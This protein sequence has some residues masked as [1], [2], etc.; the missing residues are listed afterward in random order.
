M[1]WIG[2][3]QVPRNYGNV[4]HLT[5]SES[6]IRGRVI[7]HLRWIVIVANKVESQA[8]S[9]VGHHIFSNDTNHPA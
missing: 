4:F 9:G 8:G 3:I 5:L 6:D 2:D 7:G 1:V